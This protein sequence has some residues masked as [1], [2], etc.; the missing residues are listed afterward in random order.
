[1][2]ASVTGDGLV[3]IWDM[4]ISTLDPIVSEKRVDPVR[5]PACLCATPVACPL[6]TAGRQCLARS[7]C[8]W[9]VPSDDGGGRDKQDT[10]QVVVPWCIRFSPNANVVVAGDDSGCVSV[11]KLSGVDTTAYSHKDQVLALAR[12]L[13]QAPCFFRQGVCTTCAG[14]V[15]AADA[16]GAGGAAR[17]GLG[18]QGQR[19]RCSLRAAPC[20]P[21]LLCN[22]RLFCTSRHLQPG[23]PASC[24]G[25]QS[26]CQMRTLCATFHVIALT[27]PG[28]PNL[29]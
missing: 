12:P 2:L 10:G 22:K 29:R 15:R 8:A 28:S 23:R 13:S 19:P 4:S 3:N 20:D 18:C 16:R 27:H 25:S 14:Q 26:S 5:A 9:R 21:S 1:M 17:K 11:Y 6:S 24:V 7:T